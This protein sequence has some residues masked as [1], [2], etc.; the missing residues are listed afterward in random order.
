MSEESIPTLKSSEPRASALSRRAVLKGALALGGLSLLPLSTARAASYSLPQAAR[1]ALD[2]SPLI[3]ISPLHRDGRESSCH[4][5]VWF[6]VDEGA[7]LVGTGR[8]RWKTRAVQS[9]RD[10]ARIWVG[11]F[12]PVKQAGDRYRSAPTFK[13]KAELV[14]DDAV[15]GRLLTGFGKKYPDA[16]GKWRPRFESGWEDGS[17][18][19]I[20]YTPTTA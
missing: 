1:S 20:R 10:E 17:R 14:K 5:E 2:E 16:W 3:Y 8:E 19:L 13:A 11:D 9:G 18:V 6:C 12:G 4:G 7:V 15:F